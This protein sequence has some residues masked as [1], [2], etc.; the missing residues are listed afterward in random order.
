MCVDAFLYAPALLCPH[1]TTATNLGTQ[2]SKVP[3]YHMLC[4]TMPHP[5]PGGLSSHLQGAACACCD[6]TSNTCQ[7]PLQPGVSDSLLC[8]RSSIN[9]YVSI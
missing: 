1:Y 3:L 6:G 9:V 4:C 2:A 8:S 7:V 5:L